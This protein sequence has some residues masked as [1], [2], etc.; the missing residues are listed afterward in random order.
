MKIRGKFDENLEIIF[1]INENHE[2]FLEF[3]QNFKEIEQ[4]LAKIG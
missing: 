1:L 4:N 2:N 3:L